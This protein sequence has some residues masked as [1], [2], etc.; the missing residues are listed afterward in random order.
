MRGLKAP[1]RRMR[2]PAAATAWAVSSATSRLS[3]EHGPAM[4]VSEPSPMRTSPISMTVSSGWNSRLVELVGPGD[5]RHVL[6]PGHRLEPADE[7]LL[8]RSDV[9]DER[10]HDAL[11]ARAHVWLQ[12]LGEDGAL[13]GVDLR[14][15]RARRH[16]D[17]HGAC[18]FSSDR[19]RGPGLD[20]VPCRGSGRRAKQKEQRSRPLLSRHDPPRRVRPAG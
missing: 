20:R 6:D 7:R 3:I 2:A 13:D 15:G 12:A 16:H 4:T 10:D 19:T 5:G 8:A 9:A 17:E 14:F 11:G 18:S 1:P